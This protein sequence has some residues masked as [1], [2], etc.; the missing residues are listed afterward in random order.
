[1]NLVKIDLQASNNITIFKNRL[2]IEKPLLQIQ[3]KR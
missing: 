2:N 1:M 3:Q